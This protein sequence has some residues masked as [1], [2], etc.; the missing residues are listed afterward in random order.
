[1]ENM[2]KSDGYTEKPTNRRWFMLLL[3]FFLTAINYL[4][5]TNMA[6][7]APSMSSE[8]GFDAA[9]MGLLFSAF[10]WS[11]GLMQIPGGWFLEHF[12]S[13][14]AYTISLFLWSAFTVI[15]GLGRSFVSL[16]G[17][18][19][20]IGAAEA[21]AFPTNSRVVAA[22]FPNHERATATSIYTAG[23]FIGL[24]FLTPV[25][26][27]ILER[28]GWQFIFYSTGIIGIVASVFWY[29]HYRDPKAC[30]GVNAAELAYIRDGGGL[31]ERAGTTA[32]ITWS[33]VAELFKHRQFLGVYLGQFANTSTMYFFLTWFPTY[34]I[35]AKEM[36]MLKAGIYAVIPYMGALCGVLLGGYW[37]DHMLRRG[38]SL[39][40]AR[41]LPVVCGL[42]C[43]MTIMA[44][45]YAASFQVVIIIMTVAFFGQGMAAIVWSTVGDMAPADSVGLAGGVFNFVGNLAGIITP[46]VIGLIVQETGSFVG[47]MIFISAVAALGVFSFIFIVGDIHRIDSVAARQKS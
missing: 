7:A 17:I 20:A 14:I 10:A 9:T 29:I 27:L 26:F 42:L 32:A 12:G 16:F 34:L 31:A 8:L 39:S 44:A 45:N 37:S 23:E 47:A 18:R 2:K 22:W 33:Q 13:R 1:M 4:D 35:V 36:P 46:I 11:Y 21:P 30:T 25:L 24:A 38:A 5:R 15:M 3:L 19:L 28:Y 6:V 41:K 43:S 40:K